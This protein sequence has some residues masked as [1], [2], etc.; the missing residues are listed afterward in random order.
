M[1]ISDN[2]ENDEEEPALLF[3]GQVHAEEFW[4]SRSP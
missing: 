1:R 3:V 4:E 2:V